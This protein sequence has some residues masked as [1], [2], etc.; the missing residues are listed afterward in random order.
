MPIQLFQSDDENYGDVFEIRLGYGDVLIGTAE[1]HKKSET[2]PAFGISFQQ[3]DEPGEIG[4]KYPL[5]TEEQIKDFM[6][7]ETV[8]LVLEDIRNAQMLK[9]YAEKAIKFFE[10]NSE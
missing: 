10:E 5:E 3:I 8:W 2:P 9:K 7:K 6:Q 1:R 4:Q